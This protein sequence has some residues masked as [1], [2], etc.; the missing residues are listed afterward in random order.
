MFHSIRSKLKKTPSKINDYH[1]ESRLSTKVN[2]QI[3]DNNT[4]YFL[5]DKV[6]Y[7]AGFRSLIQRFQSLIQRFIILLGL[8]IISSF[9]CIGNNN[10]SIINS[11]Y[12]HNHQIIYVTGEKYHNIEKPFFDA[13]NKEKFLEEY[14]GKTILLVFWATWSKD[15]TDDISTLDNL[16]KD[17]RKLPFKIIALSQDTD[18][19]KIKNY[20]LQ[21]NIRHL[22]AFYDYKHGVFKE[23]QIAGLPT[24]YLINSEGKIKMIFKGKTAWHSDK[25]REKILSHIDG[26]FPT[27][28]NSYKKT[29]IHKVHIR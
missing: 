6:N 10:L 11:V 3:M 24:G 5:Q 23:L 28:H 21:N 27:P 29:I 2:R 19:S 1:K 14:E 4:K 22:G 12:A 20:F 13:D 25:I 17:F 16:Q 15:S 26:N 18:I 8:W 7:C 9:V